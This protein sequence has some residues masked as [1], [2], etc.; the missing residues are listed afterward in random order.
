MNI[1]ILMTFIER[2]GEQVAVLDRFVEDQRAVAGA[3]RARNWPELERALDSAAETAEC[4]SSSEK[5]R[6]SAW[7]AF[8]DDIGLPYECTVFR[9][10]LALPVEFRSTLN[11]AYRALR[12]SAMRARIE[13]E[14]LSGFVG[15]AA[16]TLREAMEALFPERK[17]RIYGK[18]GMTRHTEAGAMI[19]DTAL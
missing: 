12:L 14:A 7:L 2:T 4:V 3:V 11:D 6:G 17:C 18:T 8:L 16:E 9:A 10:S 19:L 1:D 5:A 13:N 15:S